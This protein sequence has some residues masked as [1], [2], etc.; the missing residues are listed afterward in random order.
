VVIGVLVE[1]HPEAV[2][3]FCIGALDSFEP[4]HVV[5]AS[6]Q[7]VLR[8]AVALPDPHGHAV[9]TTPIEEAGVPVQQ[10]LVVGAP[11]VGLSVGMV[12]TTQDSRPIDP[13]QIRLVRRCGQILVSFE[14]VVVQ[15]ARR[16]VGPVIALAVVDDEDGEEPEC[17]GASREKGVV[18]APIVS[19]GHSID[20]G[21][22]PSPGLA[23]PP[24]GT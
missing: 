16:A 1:G 19:H 4:E 14:E 13:A 9:P 24:L 15:V 8:Q 23:D 21:G 7:P 11:L 10:E 18:G 20:M 2:R 12:R 22:K 6:Q 5:A 3:S 17:I